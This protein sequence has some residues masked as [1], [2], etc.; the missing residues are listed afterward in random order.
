MLSQILTSKYNIFLCGFMGCGKST[1]GKTIGKELKLKFIDL[2]LYIEDA[3]NATVS[4]IFKRDGET[5]FRN[6]EYIYTKKI[7]ENHED[8]FI[9][10]M[11][12]GSIIQPTLANLVN[13]NGIV[14]FLDLPFSK[15]YKNIQRDKTHR[16]LNKGYKE[17]K[18]IYN[19]RYDI[20]K[21]SCFIR[22]ILK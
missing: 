21:K 22:A 17:L 9:I 16:P 4:N 11:G 6:L 13:N 15:C 1:V 5:Y 8:K 19:K 20:Y 7:I 18:N 14:I 12:G 2:D 10:A 3:Q